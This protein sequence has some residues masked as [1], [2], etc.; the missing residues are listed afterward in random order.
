MLTLTLRSTIFFLL[1][2]TTAV[3]SQNPLLGEYA[4]KFENP[5]TVT[6]VGEDGLI[7]RTTNNG[8][9]WVEQTTNITNVLYG[10]SIKDGISLAAGENGVILRSVD[11]GSTWDII[12]PGTLNNFNDIDL[13]GS[14]AVV[15]GDSGTIYFSVDGG[16]NWVTS[17]YTSTKKL[18]DVE[19]ISSSVGFIAGELAEVL[20]TTDGGMTW[21][22]LNTSF[23]NRNF[24]AIEVI[25]ENNICVVGDLGTIYLSNDGGN[26]WYGPNGLMYESDIKDVVFFDMNTGV[27]TGTN[28]LILRTEDGGYSWQPAVTAPGSE[29]Y[30][31]Q[32][33]SFYDA[34]I[35]ISVG[36]EGREIYTVDGGQSWSDQAPNLLAGFTGSKHSLVDLKQNYPNPFN[37]STVIS[38]ELPFSANVSV[39]VYDIAG[40]EVA[41]LF[42]GY[43]TKGNH[44]V[45]FNASN[46]SSGVYFYRLNVVN[47]SSS[48]TKV[49]KMI[50][51]K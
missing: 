42:N 14:S 21:E 19:F 29:N 50:L 17:S 8:V 13:F 31:F 12:L 32:S 15:C 11:F 10:T 39:K 33:V 16:V 35:G 7:M 1:L 23:T 28:G 45:Q 27:V 2:L 44:T 41:S 22:P 24:N 37:P 48:I 46:L 30:D 5:S 36:N 9:N 49:N 3:H 40:K 51:T 43:Q 25:D 4:V 47:G 34:N 18:N 6:I 20:K 38:Y 26:T